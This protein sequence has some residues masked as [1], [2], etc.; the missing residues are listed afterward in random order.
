MSP[1]CQTWHD[2]DT[3]FWCWPGWSVSISWPSW[4]WRLFPMGHHS[5][6][7]VF[8]ELC[9][10]QH[11]WSA[12]KKFLKYTAMA[13]NRTW[14]TG[15]TDGEL[16]RWAIMTR[17]TGRTDSELSHWAIMTERH[18]NIY[19]CIYH[20]REYL[21]KAS[22]NY[23]GEDA[24]YD[25]DRLDSSQFFDTADADLFAL[26]S[27]KTRS[28]WVNKYWTLALK[29]PAS[30][31]GRCSQLTR[32]RMVL[33]NQLRTGFGSINPTKRRYSL[34]LSN[35]CQ[36]GQSPQMAIRVLTDCPIFAPPDGR[37]G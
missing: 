23:P 31:S 36:Y 13:G 37:I 22:A 1:I 19:V 24:E 10:R 35:L 20:C 28:K 14:A 29:V 5:A 26:I 34:S 30:L 21:L 6:L 33:F 12:R 15:R 2:E 9:S 32:T 4:N 11:M 17:A 3:F 18:I 27:P 7:M 16:S 8:P 25:L